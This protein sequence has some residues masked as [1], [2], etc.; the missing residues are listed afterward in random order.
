MIRFFGRLLKGLLLIAVLGIVA[1]SL[2]AFLVIED[3]PSLKAQSAPSPKDVV[4]ARRFLQDVKSAL[5]P[6][7]PTST[8]TTNEGQLNRVIKLGARLVPGF[9]GQVRVEDKTVTGR[10]AVPVPYLKGKWVNLRA[11]VPAF[12]EGLALSDV[13]IGPVS[14][15]PALTLSLVR[16]GANQAMGEHLG[17]RLLQ[18]AA[19]MDVQDR[20]L[21]FTMDTKQLGASGSNGIMRGL[22]GALRGGDP[23]KSDDVRQYY[24]ALRQAMDQGD[25][26]TQ[27]SYLPYLKFTLDAAQA[28]AAQDG[29]E[30]AYTAALFALTL[31]CGARDFQM[32]VGGQSET[33]A[34]LR[35]NWA[36]DC[37]KL[38]LN[39]RIDS[40]RHFTT[41]AAIQAASNR[42]VAVSIGEFKEL[43]DSSQSGGFD[44]TDIAANNSGIRLSNRL[45]ATPAEAWPALLE[46]LQGERDVIIAFRGI[47]QIMSGEA[48]T[49]TYGDVDDPRYQQ[50]LNLIETRIDGLALHRP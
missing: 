31:T 35:D 33:I 1:L 29:V 38:T 46:R 37:K 12:T 41:A 11:G 39:G 49:Q 32:I 18:A 26:P 4:A 17:D 14:L 7:V 5:D 9:R 3:R 20:R 16:I 42:G 43:F 8:L 47:P 28:R 27:G 30:N 45:M 19:T 23:P 40:R 34:D 50:M 6:E 48:F 10:I 13:A 21:A 24:L 15:P 25:L 36:T 22:F 2:F 44:F